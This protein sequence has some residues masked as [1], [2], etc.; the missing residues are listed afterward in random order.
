MLIVN[1]I[2][3]FFFALVAAKT[4]MIG[5]EFKQSLLRLGEEGTFGGFWLVTYRAI[6]AGWLIALMAWLVASTRETV[7]QILLIWISTA[8]ISALGFRHSIAGATEAFY[9]AFDGASGWAW[10]INEF[11]IPAVLGNI[12]GGFLFVA[13]INHRQVAADRAAS[14]AKEDRR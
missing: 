1:L 3:T 9:R 4:Q 14:E 6:Y 8:P 5:T 7:A 13:L 11:I 2:G 10:A 12:V